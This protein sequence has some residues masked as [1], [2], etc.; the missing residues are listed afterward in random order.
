MW[1]A[2][3]DEVRKMSDAKTASALCIV[4]V[5][6]LCVLKVK[7]RLRKM[8]IEKRKVAPA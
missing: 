3:D 8:R 1:N 5:D 2:V 4:K 6:M 7:K